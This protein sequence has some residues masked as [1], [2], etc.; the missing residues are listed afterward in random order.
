MIINYLL[1][2]LS[3]FGLGIAISSAMW[4]HVFRNLSNKLI[5]ELTKDY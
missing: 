4:V 5:D 1:G 2:M 3:G